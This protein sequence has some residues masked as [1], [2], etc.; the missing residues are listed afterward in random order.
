[1]LN[2]TVDD[3]GMDTILT[4]QICTRYH[5]ACVQAGTHGPSYDPVAAGD[6][7][8]VAITYMLGKEFNKEA[9][10]LL[11]AAEDQCQ[12]VEQE[13]AVNSNLNY[14]ISQ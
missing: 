6:C 1:M 3:K 4:L 10:T 8:Y 9:L 5:Q 12:N 7:F 14:F 2:K 13:Y 11:E